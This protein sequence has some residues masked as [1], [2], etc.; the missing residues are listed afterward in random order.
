LEWVADPAVG[1]GLQ[2][3]GDDEEVLGA[4]ERDVDAV[5]D[6]EEIDP[7]LAPPVERIPQIDPK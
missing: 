5:G 1:R 3:G 4:A 6:L 7:S 2:A